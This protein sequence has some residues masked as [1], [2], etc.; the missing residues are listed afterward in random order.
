LRRKNALAHLLEPYGD[1]T[2][3][4]GFECSVFRM[5]MSRVLG[6]SAMDAFLLRIKRKNTLLLLIV[7]R[8]VATVS[9]LRDN[10]RVA[11]R[12]LDRHRG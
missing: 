1:P 11:G 3:V 4:H 10:A 6:L 7:K 12:D 2:S 8:R 9:T 5:S